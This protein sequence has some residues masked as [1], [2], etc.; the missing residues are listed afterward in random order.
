MPPNLSSSIYFAKNESK[1]YKAGN[2]IY[3][4]AKE[5]N[6]LN[7]KLPPLIIGKDILKCGFEPSVLFSKI[8]HVAYEAQMQGKFKSRKEALVWLKD[9]LKL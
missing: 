9:Y 5:L 3:E 4:K 7:K 2:D 6:I 1:T 8:L